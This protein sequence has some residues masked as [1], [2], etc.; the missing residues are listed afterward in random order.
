MSFIA[1]YITHS[2]EKEAHEL[3]TTLLNEKIIAC[4]NIF[5]IKSHYHWQGNIET[6]HEWV[7]IVKTQKKHWKILCQRVE[8]EH[9][10]T[11]PCIMR[12]KVK[13]NKAYEDWIVESTN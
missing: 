12:F 4:A 1:V 11:T 9:S 6:D 2:S 5:P 10:Y 7:S 13:A 8:E 3:S